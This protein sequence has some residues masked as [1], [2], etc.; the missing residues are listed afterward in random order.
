MDELLFVEHAGCRLACAAEGSGPPVLLIQGV[1][2]HGGGWRP[3]VD[4]LAARHCCASFDNRGMGRSLWTGASLSAGQM[5]ADAQAVMDALGWESAHVVGHSLG[6]LVAQALA[7]TARRR[8]RSLSLLCTFARGSDATRLSARM[9]WV[10]M[11]TRLGTRRARRRAFL[12]LVMPP[13][14]RAASD[15]DTLAE[16][17][18][19]LFGHDLADHPPVVMKQL[20]AMRAYDADRAAGGTGG[21]ADAG[22]ERHAR[23]HRAAAK[24]EGHRGGRAGGALCRDR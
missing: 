24:R 10:G 21:L 2:L 18:A 15:P 23:P 7:L 8:V 16:S 13:Q 17:L 5:V 19:P 12:E 14:A 20:A 1:G 3:Q 4:G 9:L 6:G 11:R 22:G